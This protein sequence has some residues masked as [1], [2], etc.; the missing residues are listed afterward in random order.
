MGNAAAVADYK[1]ILVAGLKVFVG[2]NFHIVELDLNAVKQGVVVCRAGRDLVKRIDHLDDAVEDS[3][4]DD[5]GEVAGGSREGGTDKGIRHALFV[6]TLTADEVAEALYHNAAAQHVGKA[7]DALA[8]SV[9]IL[10]GMREMLGN[11][12]G[13]IGIAR[14]LCGVL[15]AVTVYGHDAVGILINDRAARIHA[16]GAHKVAEF[17][18]AVNDLA[19]VKLVGQVRKDL[20]GKLNADADVNTVRLCG[21]I[22]VGA[23][24]F[25]PFASR[26]AR[27]NDADGSLI[28]LALGVH[29]VNV[30]DLFNRVRRCAEVKINGW[31]KLIVEVFKHDVVYVG[32]EVADRGIEQ[33]QTVLEAFCLKRGV[34]RGVKACALAAVREVDLIDVIHEID[35]FLL[36]YML[37][38]RAAEFGG[39]IVFAVRE[40]TGT[41]EAVHDGTGLAADAGFDLLAV[42]GAFA[43]GKGRARLKDRDLLFGSE[44]RKLI[45]GEDTAGTGAYDY[46]VV[47]LHFYILLNYVLCFCA[48]WRAARRKAP[49]IFAR[50]MRKC[51]A[52]AAPGRSAQMIAHLSKIYHIIISV[53]IQLF[54]EKFIDCALEMLYNIIN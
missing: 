8:V 40:R 9:G 19:L 15:V 17:F 7:S 34:C 38:K 13:E 35:R 26:T 28:L 43:L 11:E 50:F 24:L 45:C 27:R 44:P 1:E 51:S 30:A 32:A 29:A 31:G 52:G 20:I 10:E 37:V 36:A 42:N 2:V 3:L 53:K 54:F 48:P 21:N 41:A 25:H 18:G 47:I 46:N 22:E 14:V 39:D 23:D 4:G 12:Q 6:G 49:C 16:E 5:K 33:M